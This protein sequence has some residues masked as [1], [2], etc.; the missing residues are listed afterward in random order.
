[1]GQEIAFCS[2]DGVETVFHVD[3]GGLAWLA[4]L[5]GLAC[6][7]AGDD[8][9]PARVRGLAV[10]ESAD[11]RHETSNLQ[12]LDH[13]FTEETAAFTWAVGGAGLRLESTW[14]LDRTAGIWSRQD[15]LHNTGPAAVT[16]R[17]VLAR[18]PFA[19][20]RYD[21]YSQGSDWCDENQGL[22]RSLDHGALVLGCHGGRTTQGG[23]PFVALRSRD[24]GPGV[25]FHLIARGNWTI[26][27]CAQEAGRTLPPFAVVEL[28]LAHET[29]NRVL[30]PG[31]AFE[32]P[33]VLIQALPGSDPVLAAPDLHRYALRRYFAAAKPEA[34]VV[35]NTW[36]DTFDSL[37]V[38][39]MRR[40]LAAAADLG[41]EVFT[42]DAGWYG[43]GPGSWAA[44]VGDWR[45][46][47]DG[48][49]FGKM[50]GFADEVRAAGL[51]FG[52]WVEPERNSPTAP[53]VQ[54]HP[55]WFL[56]GAD[57]FR[58]P[59]LGQP[60]AYAHILGELGRLV[61]AYGLAWMK[62]DFNFEL[63]ADASGLAD[64]YARWYALLDTLRGRYPRTFFEGC[65]SGG[66]RSD[67]N[68]LAH[69]SGHFL[70]D[71]VEPVDVLRITQGA[72]LRLPPGRLA[73]WAVLRSVGKAIV[74]YGHTPDD[75]PDTLVVPADAGW[76]TSVS[77]HVD[78][79]ARA[80]LTGMFGLSGDIASLPEAARERLWRHVCFFKRWR[81]F[82]A[83]SVAHLLTPPR[84]RTDRDGW[85]GLQLQA[86]DGDRS[87][88]FAYRL[89]GCPARTWLPL[90][91]LAPDRTYLV[92]DDDRPDVPPR[93]V[94]GR[95]LLGRGLVV[96]LPDVNSAAVF[97]VEA[98]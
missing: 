57:G 3:E 88:V 13:L 64:Y 15:T 97:I 98:A 34:P 12:L 76:R 49:F 59:D 30:S 89:T 44:Q 78:F 67:L 39:R 74:R 32:L 41:C 6:G 19:P 85:I 80:A 20:G 16:L 4:R 69:F 71:T 17:R 68:T 5:C 54:A 72:L 60:E 7:H 52:L 93:A 75:V 94:P 27:V 61:E 86:P 45:E 82:I 18:F 81:G 36:F 73:K 48:A 46:K 91:G 56:P 95:E 35:Y 31:E 2:E 40:Q 1:M 63:G 47:P 37:D 9:G 51:G 92:S 42:V 79:A 84:P 55:G 43:A 24:G 28:G 96:E 77:A 25:A 50:A 8:R 29:L 26:S 65:A 90:R 14:R 83:S 66:M 10:V 62:V 53:A 58:Y 87:L 22:W 38:A 33:E 70:S 23:T 21:V 11:G